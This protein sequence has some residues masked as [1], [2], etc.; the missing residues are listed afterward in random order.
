L[1]YSEWVKRKQAE[2]LS[3]QI[4]KPD[5]DDDGGF[6]AEKP[7]DQGGVWTTSET[8]FTLLKYKLLDA[9]DSRIQRAKEWLIRHRNLGADYG[10]GWPLI[11]RGNSFVD[12]TSLTI[13]ALSFFKDDP[14][15]VE[16][17]SKAK[18]WLIE[19]QNEDGGWSIW[20]Y[21]DSLVS[22]TSWALLALKQ[23][24][25]LFPQDEK[26][27][28]AILNGTTWLKLTQNQSNQLWGFK[29][30]GNSPNSETNNASTRMAV[31]ALFQLGENLVDYLPA[32]KS[33]LAEF[34]S[35][36]RWRTIPETYTLKY[37]GEGLDQRL[38]W[39]NAP[40]VLAMLVAYAKCVPHSVEIK[41]VID[42]A[43]SLKKFDAKYQS[44]EVTDISIG[45]NL[46][47]RPWAS[48]QY[49][50]GLL[51][52][53]SY[54]QAHL[55]EYVAVMGKKV[56]LIEKAG[57]LKSL[58]IV[59]PLKRATSVY[60]SGMFLVI[61]LPALGLGLV[62]IAYLTH[63]FGFEIAVPVSL[64][65]VYMVTFVALVLGYRQK[66]VSKSK[67]LFLYFPVW[68]LAVTGTVLFFIGE[69][70]EALVVLLLI[71]FPEILSL[72]MNKMNK[73]EHK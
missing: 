4:N 39:F 56:A 62:G 73:E 12:T 55:D 60:V 50:R 2:V 21:E 72:V 48:V 22:A 20:K 63:L 11:N 41:S 67:F 3:W 53:E 25:D 23:M 19:N 5:D 66:V 52:A 69:N 8:I 33:F 38:S 6:C 34:E 42:G 27:K 36:G 7:G 32:L 57:M 54:L 68:A 65:A 1:V 51:E 47:I 14:E 46:D 64:F 10:N 45:G 40:F 49:L 29:A 61:L 37:F 13:I 26:S 70:I 15:A 18:D 9:S 16:A 28:A 35:E 43:E 24:V 44:Q 59:L 30:D 17:I 58:P 71:G 31:Y